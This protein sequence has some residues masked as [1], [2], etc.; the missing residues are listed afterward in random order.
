MGHAAITLASFVS[1]SY[2]PSIAGF[3]DRSIDDLAGPC[4]GYTQAAEAFSGCHLLLPLFRVNYPAYL[5]ENVRTTEILFAPM[6]D[7]VC[8]APHKVADR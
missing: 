7:L 3:G 2:R 1:F 6:G 8:E 5:R 4:R